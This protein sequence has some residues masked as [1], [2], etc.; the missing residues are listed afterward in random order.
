MREFFTVEQVRSYLED[1]GEKIRGDKNVI[2]ALCKQFPE[3]PAYPATRADV[4]A[5]AVAIRLIMHE[6]W[7]VKRTVLKEYGYDEE[8]EGGEEMEEE[9]GEWEEMEGEW[10]EWEDEED[11]GLGVEEEEGAGEEV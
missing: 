11:E 1:L 6:S 9:E 8:S 2:L 10:E 3:F 5:F 7:H 4:Q